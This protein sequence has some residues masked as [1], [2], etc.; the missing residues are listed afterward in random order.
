MVETF[1]VDEVGTEILRSRHTFL[2]GEPG[3]G[4]STAI[5][6]GERLVRQADI[7]LAV[8]STT[9]AGLRRAFQ[10]AHDRSMTVGDGEASHASVIVFADELETF[11]KNERY[12]PELFQLLTLSYN[13]PPILDH[14]TQKD[15]VFE[16]PNAFL[17][18]LGGIQPDNLTKRI[19]PETVGSGFASRVTF[20]YHPPQF[21]KYSWNLEEVTGPT[22]L[23]V[24]LIQDLAHIAT[25]QGQY[26]VTSGFKELWDAIGTES[27]N[28]EV[29]PLGKQLVSYWRRRI[30]HLTKLSI[31]YAASRTDKLT[32]TKEDLTRALK[33]LTEAEEHM[34]YVIGSLTTSEE[35]LVRRDVLRALQKHGKQTF[36]KLYGFYKD[37]FSA[38]EMKDKILRDLKLGGQIRERRE[39]TLVYFEAVEE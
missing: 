28:Q 7:A 38:L 35:G 16:V 36:E 32:L 34:P 37:D 3:T 27:A 30:T 1:A 23:E 6:I 17:T 10:R 31:V 8:S 18:V 39:G 19:P 9:S 4:K 12:D 21:V 24:K 29:C 22:E 25:L 13:C 5:K 11:L 26:A 20:I 2:V 14:E 15:G 33:T